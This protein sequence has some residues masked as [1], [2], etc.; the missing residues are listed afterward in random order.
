MTWPLFSRT[1]CKFVIRRREL[2]R[3]FLRFPSSF[4]SCLVSKIKH[5]CDAIS[6]NTLR[7]FDVIRIYL[8]IFFSRCYSTRILSR[9]F[10]WGFTT[11]RPYVTQSSASITNF[12]GFANVC[13]ELIIWP[14]RSMTFKIICPK[15]TRMHKSHLINV[16]MFA[17]QEA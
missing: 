5:E 11:K 1:L 6:F 12:N 2:K 13:E 9:V 15:K 7:V 14:L 4:S 8:R 3:E 16:E 10:Y 17:R